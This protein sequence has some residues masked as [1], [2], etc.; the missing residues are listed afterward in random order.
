MIKINYG[1][2]LNVKEGYI[3]HGCN[4]QGFMGAGVARQIKSKYYSAYSAYRSTYE[5]FKNGI[6]KMPVGTNSYYRADKRDG[7]GHSNLIIVNAITQEFFGRERKLYVSY[8]AIEECFR[9][10]NI[11]IINGLVP[12]IPLNVN[13]PMLGCGLGGGA[14]LKIEK[15]IDKELDDAIK[16]NL[17]IKE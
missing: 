6:G 15:I 13:F 4:A 12:G 17:W 9:K 14:W 10:L 8:K 1:D 11:F 3:I 16:K 5:N 7:T 2:L